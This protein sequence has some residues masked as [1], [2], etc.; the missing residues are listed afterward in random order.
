MITP[1]DTAALVGLIRV[2][3]IRIERLIGF[4]LI[5]EG[6]AVPEHGYL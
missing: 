1:S 3:E 5:P 6:T 4:S 2:D